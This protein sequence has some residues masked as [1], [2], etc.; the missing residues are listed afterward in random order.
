M[1]SLED[2]PNTL[3]QAPTSVSPL[4]SPL[5]TTA[6]N[7]ASRDESYETLERAQS[8]Y[9]PLSTFKLKRDR[10]YKQQY[11]DMYFLRLAKIKP[12]VER[13][14]AEAWDDLE[15]AGERVKKVDRV[16]DVRQGEL[17]WVVGTVYMAMALKPDILED[18]SNDVRLLH[19]KPLTSLLPRFNADRGTSAGSPHPSPR[20]STSRTTGVTRS[21]WRTTRA[22][23]SS[24]ATS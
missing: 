6:A 16:L 4:Q 21:C 20:Q 11:G 7:T 1:V 13:V 18:V 2:V 9:K 12:A 8:A 22:A 14:A 23:S 15:I 24:S 17:C 19:P 3:L 5:F 10:S